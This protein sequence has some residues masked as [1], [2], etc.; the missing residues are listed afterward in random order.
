HLDLS[1]YCPRLTMELK[2]PTGASKE[3]RTLLLGIYTTGQLPDGFQI[4]RPPARPICL[5]S[6]QN[7]IA[8]Q[9]GGIVVPP[10][11]PLKV[12][13]PDVQ[14][15]V[16]QGRI[17]LPVGWQAI[18]IYPLL[19]DEHWKP[20]YA[21]TWAELDILAIAAQRNSQEKQLNDIDPRSETRRQYAAFLAEFER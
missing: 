9:L 16:G 4:P 11:A 5:V 17:K 12:D 18:E 2:D 15:F 10:D 14:Q 7:E 8:L 13:G 19:G 3:T 6:V 20:E 1:E 21:A